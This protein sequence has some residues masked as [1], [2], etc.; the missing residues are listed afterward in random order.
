MEMV[1]DSQCLVALDVVEVN[2]ILDTRNST[3][4]SRRGTHPL[5]P[6]KEYSLA[7]NHEDSNTPR[8][9]FSFFASSSLRG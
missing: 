4:I 5:G 9:K 6:G 2:P 7:T 8:N 3:A 1:A